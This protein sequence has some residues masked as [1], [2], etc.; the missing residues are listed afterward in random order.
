MSIQLRPAAPVINRPALNKAAELHVRGYNW[1]QL[2]A[3]P[4]TEDQIFGGHLIVSGMIGVMVAF[5]IGSGITAPGNYFFLSIEPQLYNLGIDTK[6]KVLTYALI[7]IISGLGLI[8]FGW[9]HYRNRILQAAALTYAKAWGGHLIYIAWWC[10]A[11][12]LWSLLVMQ[13]GPVLFG[14]GLTD[15]ANHQA[16]TIW[17]M[18]FDGFLLLLACALLIGGVVTY[19]KPPTFNRHL[20]DPKAQLHVNLV[21]F[22]WTGMLYSAFAWFTFPRGESAALG[23]WSDVT[24]NLFVWNHVNCCALYI[25]G[26]VFHGAQYLWDVRDDDTKNPWVISKWI[27]WFDK[28]DRQV[29]ISVICFFF[30]FFT[31]FSAWGVM[32]INS[33]V[34]F[35]IFP[36]EWYIDWLRPYI[37]ETIWPGILHVWPGYQTSVSDWVFLHALTSGFF[38]VMIPLSRA[39]FFTRRSPLFDAKGITKRSFDYPCLGPAY[40]GTCGFSIQDQI[41]LAMLWSIKPLSVIVW[42][43]MGAYF[44]SF[45]YAIDPKDP[46]GPLSFPGRPGTL[47][48]IFQATSKIWN[49]GH[50]TMTLYYGHLVWLLSFMF[51]FMYR[52]SRLEGAYI[53]SRFLKRH[54]NINLVPEQFVTTLVGSRFLGTCFY[55]GGTFTCIFTYLAVGYAWRPNIGVPVLVP[56]PVPLPTP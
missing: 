56:L 32:G 48:Y 22:G 35:K 44:G 36:P 33:L 38:F 6:E 16:K 39:V 9:W 41:W 34:D 10:F 18:N 51:W 26:G 1:Y 24:L 55:Y 2:F 25:F 27:R 21:I 11:W 17:I 12:N 29:D 42:Y 40:G 54:F 37:L 46:A 5:N 31:G 3:F 15:A 19:R 23:Q 52:G 49:D 8:L 20:E 45:Q 43:M 14:T 47:F 53:L 30:A 4:R 50:L 28:E 13:R 7:H